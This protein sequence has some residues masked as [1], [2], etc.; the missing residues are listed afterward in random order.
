[1]AKHLHFR[2]TQE[3]KLD[4]DNMSKLS[5]SLEALITFPATRAPTVSAQPNITAACHAI[6]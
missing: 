1:M 2:G 5:N 6:Q 3:P 4:N